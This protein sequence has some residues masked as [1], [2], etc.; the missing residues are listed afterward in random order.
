MG[1]AA[2]LSVDRGAK[3]LAFRGV[4]E[5]AVRC[6]DRGIKFPWSKLVQGWLLIR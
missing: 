2:V 4:K 3:A 6:L 5:Q 1:G